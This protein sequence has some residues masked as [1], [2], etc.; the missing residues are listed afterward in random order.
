MNITVY[1]GASASKNE[2]HNNT[3]IELG[4]WIAKSN[5]T[6]VYGGGSV[7]LMGLIANT[8]LDNDAKVIGV[9]PEF[10]MKRELS[11]PKVENM[12]V[13]KT[14]GERKSKMIELG[15]CYIALPGGLGT[16]EEIS[17]VISW[18]RIGQNNNP[19][20]L[21]NATGYYDKLDE[22][23]KTMVNE[24]FLSKEDYSKILFAKSME[25]I[26]VFIKNYTPP[27]IREYK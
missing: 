11:H 14:M 3:A 26:N 5:Y 25:E 15:D 19:C 4:Q 22:F 13:V 24:G 17:E 8:V 20:V 27:K 9:I 2:V 1:C 23:L 10:L 7:G 6:L 21:Y 12:Q 18:I 16:L